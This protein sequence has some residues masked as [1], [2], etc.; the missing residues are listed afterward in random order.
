MGK[1]IYTAAEVVKINDKRGATN[2]VA[3]PAS[4][5]LD[6][7]ESIIADGLRTFV[8]VGRA[9]AEIRDG[10]LYKE[11]GFKTFEAY[12]RRRWEMGRSRAY[13]LID[14]SAFVSNVHFSGQQ[15]AGET[16]V[17][18][19][20]KLPESE[21]E[22]VWEMAVETA[23]DGKVTAR[24]VAKLV[25]DRLLES[26]GEASPSENW[27]AEIESRKRPPLAEP[28]QGGAWTVERFA[29]ECDELEAGDVIET[30]VES[31]MRRLDRP[32][33][34]QLRLTLRMLEKRILKDG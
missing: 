27:K 5:D 31:C 17:R 10:K 15:P 22:Q 21:R 4:R 14:A 20:L 7:Q 23:P 3:F 25:R 30:I 1:S 2:V 9:L 26:H 28:N 18:P 34:S 32:K 13:Q 12:C 19:L 24:H 6:Q 11:G 29:S 33:L 8:E 16:H